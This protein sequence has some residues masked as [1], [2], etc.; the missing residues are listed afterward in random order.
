MSECKQCCGT[1]KYS[2]YD[3]MQGY[4]CV[5]D[6]SEYVGDYVEKEF[7]CPDWDG[8]EEDERGLCHRKKMLHMILTG[9]NLEQAMNA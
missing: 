2:S 5:N 3:K 4:V 1:C 7:S 9:P 8:S 6:E